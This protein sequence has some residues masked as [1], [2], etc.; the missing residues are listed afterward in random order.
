MHLT[1]QALQD[2]VDELLCLKKKEM[3]NFTHPH[4][5]DSQVL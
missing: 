3:K 5:C 4:S 2:S 1:K